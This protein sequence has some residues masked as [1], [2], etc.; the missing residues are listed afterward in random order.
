[1][2][3]ID[4]SLATPDDPLA[5]DNLVTL[6]EPSARKLTVAV[7]LPSSHSAFEPIKRILGVLPNVQLGDP[8]DADL[9]IGASNDDPPASRNTWWIGIGPSVSSEEGK[10]LPGTIGPFLLEKQNP[11]MDGIVM[12][13]VV[14][15]GIDQLEAELIPIISAGSSILLGQLPNSVGTAYLLNIDLARS[16]LTETPDWPIFWTNL[17]QQCQESRPG[18]RR[19]NYRLDE[20]IAFTLPSELLEKEEEL[21]LVHEGDQK[22]LVRM[23]SILISPRNETGIYEIYDGETLIDRF[24]VN[25][26]D[27]DESNLTALN[28]G[29][30]EPE[31]AGAALG[32]HVDNPFSWM[33]VLGILVVTGAL[34]WDWTITTQQN[35]TKPAT[36]SWQRAST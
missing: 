20:S 5:I 9:I 6:I 22:T 26:F 25:F 14:W 4:L 13:G 21:K 24:A 7:T 18:F 16:N 17:M 3:Q 1:M 36:P 12:G 27:R 31:Q 19:W 2:R 15:G 30:R 8:A 11:L 10:E 34:L 35:R 32:I 28:N 29:R 23:E 33:L